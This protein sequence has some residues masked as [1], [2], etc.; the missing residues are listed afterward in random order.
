M[1]L[2]VADSGPL[3]VFARAELLD[4]V[5]QV[6]GEI[7]VPEIV[8][9]ECSQ[10]PAKPGARAVIEAHRKRLFTVIPE[11]RAGGL[12]EVRKVANLDAG[13]LAV[14]ALAISKRCPVLIDERLGRDVAALNGLTVIGSAGI[15][16]AAK[17]RGLIDQVA[18][19]LTAWRDWRYF[20]SPALI[21]TVLS[22]AGE[23]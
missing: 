1:K 20:L 10:D 13:E 21:Q 4:V 17:K 8:F 12:P 14:I 18:P 5:K 16:V 7:L 22:K 3:I 23:A 9:F 19:I 11:K 2:I 15:L 6:A